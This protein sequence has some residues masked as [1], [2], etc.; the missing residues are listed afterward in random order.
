[1]FQLSMTMREREPMSTSKNPVGGVPYQQYC[2]NCQRTFYY[3]YRVHYCPECEDLIYGEEKFVYGD[4]NDQEALELERIR[5]KNL[6]KNCT[7]RS[8]AANYRY[9]VE[10]DPLPPEMGNMEGAA[11]NK[12]EVEALLRMKSIDPGAIIR[13]EGQIYTRRY[14]VVCAGK[15]KV[16][17]LVEIKEE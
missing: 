6:N 13:Y 8:I 4:H 10:Y 12:E 14:R 9:T 16:Y 5:S 2:E 11:L 3:H 17:K 7:D 15:M 1:M